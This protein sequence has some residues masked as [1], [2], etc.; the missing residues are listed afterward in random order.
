MHDLT[1]YAMH[2]RFSHDCESVT[3]LFSLAPTVANIVKPASSHLQHISH[4]YFKT[5]PSCQ[6]DWHPSPL[7]L[8]FSITALYVS[9]LTSHMIVVFA[10]A[11]VNK[12]NY[13]N[14]FVYLCSTFGVEVFILGRSMGRATQKCAVRELMLCIVSGMIYSTNY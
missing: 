6:F 3:A 13:T 14:G 5:P 7:P 1:R 4:S 11:K 9:P 8:S 10:Y 12:S 2:V